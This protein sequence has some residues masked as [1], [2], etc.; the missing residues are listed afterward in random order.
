MSTLDIEYLR[1]ADD[2][3]LTAITIEPDVRAQESLGAL[4]IHGWTG[5]CTEHH[6]IALAKDLAHRGVPVVVANNRGAHKAGAAVEFFNDCILDIDCARESLEKR[7]CQDI[8]YAGHSYGGLKAAYYLATQKVNPAGLVLMSSVPSMR[9][10]SDLYQK[11]KTLIN[12]ESADQY[13][14]RMEGE[15]LAL[16]HAAAVIR[17]YEDAYQGTTLDLLNNID[18]PL[19]SMASKEEW[20]WF[21]EVSK[22]IQK[23]SEKSDRVHTAILEGIGDH[24]Y[25]GFEEKAATYVGNWVEETYL[26]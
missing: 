7:G 10:Q 2:V 13:F 11:A 6:L 23:I 19:L 4:L 26:S 5:K 18:C 17:H 25:A 9:V 20:D 14:A 22:E 16:Y 8:I 3:S 15:W 1:T 24:V 21:H 12:A